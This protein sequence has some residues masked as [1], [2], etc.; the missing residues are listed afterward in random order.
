VS[1]ISNPSK[2]VG[3]Y[4][5]FE[6]KQ[7]GKFNF[8]SNSSLKSEYL[9]AARELF[10]KKI[11]AV[12]NIESIKIVNSTNNEI[13]TEYLELNYDEDASLRKTN[14]VHSGH[15]DCFPVA[16]DDLYMSQIVYKQGMFDSESPGFQDW[17]R[18]TCP[19]YLDATGS[20]IMSQNNPYLFT[21][22]GNLHY[23]RS[24]IDDQAMLPFK[25]SFLE[26]N[27][28]SQSGGQAYNKV[29]PGG[30]IYAIDASIYNSHGT[31]CAFDLN[32]VSFRE[33]EETTY[34]SQFT[35]Y[36]KI[37]EQNYNKVR[38]NTIYSTFGQAEK[39]LAS[40]EKTTFR[41]NHYFVMP[42][43]PSPL[44]KFVVQIGP[45]NSDNDFSITPGK[46]LLDGTSGKRI[47]QTYFN[48]PVF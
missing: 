47:A 4:I 31:S 35:N 23:A 38:D 42:S 25:H 34:P 39:F 11:S 30:D 22:N 41:I 16:G 46:L 9:G 6:Y 13:T 32:I 40:S 18:Y 36:R 8:H 12:H 24:H 19:K 5:K 20:W 26:S 1:K 3:Y 10:L 48:H 27:K 43:L 37:S 7:Y 45:S 28:L 44:S 15:T 17:D 21:D 14:M 33:G 29:M 2:H